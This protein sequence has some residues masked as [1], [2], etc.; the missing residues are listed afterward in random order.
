MERVI[1][2]Y[3]HVGSPR[4]GTLNDALD[5]MKR[6]GISKSV[7]V[8]A[9]TVPDFKNL[10]NGIRMFPDILRGIGIPFGGSPS[11]REALVDLQLRAGVS[12][13]RMEPEEVKSNPRILERLGDA[14][15]WIFAINPF[16]NSDVTEIYLNWLARFPNGR[17]AAPH[18][19]VTET[20]MEELSK[21]PFVKELLS[22][23]RFYVIF[24]R[25]GGLGSRLPYPHHD[26]IPWIHYVLKHAGIERVMWG[27]EFPVI[28]SRNESMMQCREWL[29]QLRLDLEQEQIQAIMH[30]N[31]ERVFFSETGPSHSDVHLP[32]W[33]DEQF[34]HKQFVLVYNQAP[35]KVPVYLY[36][37]LLTGYLKS[38]ELQR[39][40]IFSQYIIN[41]LE[42][43]LMAE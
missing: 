39:G 40:D 15:R 16:G 23:P 41:K 8:L 26:F 24:S 30:D 4:Y 14:G 38:E 36:D 2:A 29:S 28:Y 20:Q 18:L 43:C 34:D 9:K 21:N 6:Y 10:F 33:I 35:V 37:R 27:S 25:H 22:H 32:E 11:E 13:L 5:N 17:I 3:S 31:A 12:G 19:L 42:Q 7:L 1:D